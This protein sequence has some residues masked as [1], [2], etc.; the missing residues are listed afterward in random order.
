MARRGQASDGEGQKVKPSEVLQAISAAK[1]RSLLK[2]GR[3]TQAD[4]QEIAGTFGN[5][6]KS[7]VENHHL[8]RKAFAHI[9]ALDRMEPEKL[10]DY[11]AHFEHMYEISGLRERAE[12]AQRLPMGDD[13]TELEA[14]EAEQERTG[15]GR[16]GPRLVQPNG[17]ARD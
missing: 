2:D 4:I 17:E 16:G 12:S 5:A 1:L 13:Q 11:M 6:V 8:H 9:R 14:D 10:A 15:K 3:A 7:A